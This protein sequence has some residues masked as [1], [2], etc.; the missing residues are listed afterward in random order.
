MGLAH[1]EFNTF[2]HN[3][4]IGAH[5]DIPNLL[6]CNGFSRHGFQQAPACGRG[7]AELITYGKYHTLDLS[8]LSYERIANNQPLLERAVI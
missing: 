6:L 1:Y 8:A 7:I 2:D 5:T 3:A 4:I